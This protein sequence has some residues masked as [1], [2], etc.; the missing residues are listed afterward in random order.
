MACGS[1]GSPQSRAPFPPTNPQSVLLGSLLPTL[2]IWDSSH[3][4]VFDPTHYSLNYGPPFHKQFCSP[5]EK[6]GSLRLRVSVT[7]VSIPWVFHEALSTND[8]QQHLLY[9]SNALKCLLTFLFYIDFF[10]SSLSFLSYLLMAFLSSF[11]LFQVWM[12]QTLTSLN[13]RSFSVPCFQIF[14]RNNKQSEK[15]NKEWLMDISD[16]FSHF[17]KVR[18]CAQRF[19]WLVSW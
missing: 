7:P 15:S 12:N 9:S 6:V 2:T 3:H 5:K 19:I 17:I 8:S 18:P 16:C 1:S 13:G 4:L 10:L 11:L 14:Q